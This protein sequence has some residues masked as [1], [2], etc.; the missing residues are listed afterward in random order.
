M[1][2]RS[3]WL[4][5]LFHKKHGQERF[6]IF[7]FQPHLSQQHR[8]RAKSSIM[9]ATT[10]GQ[11]DGC[12]GTRKEVHC[13][14][15]CN[16]AKYCGRD[17]QASHWKE[18]KI[19]CDIQHLCR[20]Q[21]QAILSLD[22]ERAALVGSK[23]LRLLKQAPKC[24]FGI[25]YTSMTDSGIVSPNRPLPSG[26]PANFYMK[27]YAT[28]QFRMGPPSS[29]SRAFLKGEVA[30]K[31]Y[32]D[33]ICANKESWMDFFD[34]PGN[35]EHTKDTY[36]ILFGLSLIYG[37]RAVHDAWEPLLDMSDKVFYMY[38]RHSSS[39]RHI[40]D[41][42]YIMKAL[43]FNLYMQQRR[44]DEMIPLFRDQCHY[45]LKYELDSS[46]RNYLFVI[47]VLLGKPP[48]LACLC[49]LSDAQLKQ[50]VQFVSGLMEIPRMQENFSDLRQCVALM[51]C[52]GCGKQEPALNVFKKC[53]RCLQVYYCGRDCQLSHWKAHKKVCCKKSK[54]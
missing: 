36:Q 42:Q 52:A 54:K 40:E 1:Q 53:T 11:C 45:E 21:E 48:T 47:L 12:K 23:L 10:T 16:I 30:Y 51:I 15:R 46:T 26:V 7:A 8:H 18:H 43:R 37:L 50:C 39:V 2:G 19:R 41:Q 25:I 17:C 44:F 3:Q 31:E 38:K 49:S 27:Q 22:M 34:K 4:L 13:C 28:V 32:Y 9:S 24:P 6:T 29:H 20:E 14:S 5:K 35:H 33:E